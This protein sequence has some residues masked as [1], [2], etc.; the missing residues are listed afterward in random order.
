MRSNIGYYE[1]LMRRTYPDLNIHL[2][3][4]DELAEAM[5]SLFDLHQRRWRARMLPGVLGG[6]CVQGFHQDVAS[7]FASRG[8]LR[9]HL[10]RAEGRIVSA[11]YCYCYRDRYY[12]YLGGF[13]PNLARYSP[14][15]VLTAHAVRT[16]IDEGCS[17]FDFLRGGETY[18]YRWQPE[19]PVNV[20]LLLR[21][22]SRARSAAMLWLNRMERAAEHHAKAFAENRGRRKAQ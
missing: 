16:A 4:G 20:R 17:I 9:L 2:A 7:R 5:G 8:W 3:A 21:G 6:A 18:K 10:M 13:E 12:Y 15:T 14:G 19:L 11:L 22:S 1:R